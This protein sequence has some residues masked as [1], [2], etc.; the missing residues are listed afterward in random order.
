MWNLPS[1]NLGTAIVAHSGFSKISLTEWHSADPDKTARYK[2]SHLDLHCLHRYL[3]VCRNK[4]V[5]VNCLALIDIL[6][7]SNLKTPL[8]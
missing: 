5:N 1:P 6:L 7:M 2:S 4:R 3:L 8:L